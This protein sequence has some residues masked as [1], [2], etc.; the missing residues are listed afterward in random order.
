MKRVL[1]LSTALVMI[2][3]FIRAQDTQEKSAPALPSSQ[4]IVAPDSSHPAAQTLRD[5]LFR[6]VIPATEEK[7]TGYRR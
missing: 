1:L 6:S 7:A 5:V 3:T 2:F 4:N